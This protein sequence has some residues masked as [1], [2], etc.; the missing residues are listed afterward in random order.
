MKKP[1]SL[2]FLAA[3]AVLLILGVQAYSSAGS[4]V[5]RLFTGAPTH[6]ATWLLA[7]AAVAIIVGLGGIR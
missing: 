1:I 6:E 3:G 7:G 5:S 4:S 2:A